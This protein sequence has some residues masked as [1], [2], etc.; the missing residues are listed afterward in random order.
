M[1]VTVSIDFSFTAPNY[2][3]LAIV[4]GVSAAI[5]GA[6]IVVATVLVGYRKYK[7][8]NSKGTS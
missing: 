2:F 5:F 7:R 6:L 4:V 8:G 3:V 1:N